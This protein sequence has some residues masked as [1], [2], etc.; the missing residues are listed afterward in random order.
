MVR[1]TRD[2][3]HGCSIAGGFG[4]RGIPVSVH[5][6]HI[7]IAGGPPISLQCTSD[8]FRCASVCIGLFQVEVV[9]IGP[10]ST[11]LDVTFGC[12]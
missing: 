9:G 6:A 1:V 12:S 11:L 7:G 3:M 10:T 4:F 2:V 8:I 5:C